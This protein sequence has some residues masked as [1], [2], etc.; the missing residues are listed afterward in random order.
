MYNVRTRV[1]LLF[2][3]FCILYAI[4]IFNL[5]LI[6]IWN[7][8]F[9]STLGEQQYQVTINQPPPRAAIFDRTGNHYLAMNKEC[10]S[11]FII[12]NELK[13]PEELKKF[14]Q[15]NFPAAYERLMQKPDRSFMY[16]KR[17]LSH[18]EQELIAQA[19]LADIHLLCEESRYYP[20]ASA[21][22]LIGFTD[23]DNHGCSGI[24]LSCE[25]QLAGMPSKYA[26]EK[27]ARSGFYYFKKELFDKGK[28]GNPIRLTIDTDLQYLVDE[29][30]AKAQEKFNA[31]ET[32][33][34][35]MDPITGDI[36]A[37][38]SH[39][40]AHVN[41]AKLFNLDDTKH[42]VVADT[43]ELG[44]VIK[45]FAALAAI[46]EEV[47]QVDE[48]IDCKNTLSCYIDGRKINTVKANGKISF[49]DVV[50]FSNNIGIAQ[51]A[52]RLGPALY[53][54]YVR[55]GFGNKTGIELPGE[56]SGFVNH[57]SHWSKQSI[58]S[59][60]YGYE[61]S[62]TLLQ[63]ATAFCMI[64][65][66]GKKVQ[67]RLILDHPVPTSHEQ[68]YS[69]ESIAA[70]KDILK[71]TAEHGTGW[72]TQIAGYNIMTK[73]GTANKLINGQYDQRKNL[74]TCAAIIEKDNYKRVVVTFVNEA[75]VANAFA[76]TIAAPIVREIAERMIIHDRAV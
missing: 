27:D 48:I 76:S 36:L 54:H 37:M 65:Q 71:R 50:A 4:I 56:Q 29:E 42:R 15:D 59:L 69:P 46:Q 60:S 51:V 33:A 41:D 43:H 52:K 8:H 14:L 3:A 44:S 64:A 40:Y 73:T 66:D 63:L 34:I 61:I 19:D 53:D 67:P 7:T 39:P 5:F 25:K 35:V 31:K 68:L 2:G 13:R 45:V 47:V 49:A 28:E 1:A 18:D 24:E 32:A 16:I 57:P 22:P 30:L 26:L 11:A 38:A 23:I 55:M 58:I 9:F 6:Q 12:P 62:A 20:L 21:S 10:V 74:Y 75:N 17:R 72:R 70:I